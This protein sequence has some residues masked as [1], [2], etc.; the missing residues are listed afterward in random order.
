MNVSISRL[1]TVQVLQPIPVNPKS[2][3]LGQFLLDYFGDSLTSVTV[4]KL[5]DVPRIGPGADRLTVLKQNGVF[6]RK[7]WI[8]ISYDLQKLYVQLDSSRMKLLHVRN[9]N[10]LLSRIRR[11]II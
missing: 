11:N 3:A 9:M 5:S 6:S 4:D 2:I 7:L 1:S 10:R 8:Y